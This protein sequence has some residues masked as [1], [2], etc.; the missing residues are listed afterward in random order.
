MDGH[1][2][3]PIDGCIPM[4]R[5]SGVSERAVRGIVNRYSSSTATPSV[6]TF[7]W[8]FASLSSEE[9]DGAQGVWHTSHHPSSGLEISGSARLFLT[10]SSNFDI[11][12]KSGW[13][14]VQVIGQIC[15]GGFYSYRDGLVSL[16]GL[17]QEVF[18]TQPTRLF[19]H[20]LYIRGSLIERWIFDRSGMYCCET[21]NT[22]DELPRLFSLVLEY[23]LLPHDDLGESDIVKNDD[24]GRFI[25]IADIATS[26]VGQL[27]L[28][29]KPIA[30]A[31]EAFGEGTTCYRAKKLESDRWNFVVKFKWRLAT[32]RPEEELLKLANEK[33]VWGIVSLDYHKDMSRTEKLR[34]WALTENSRL[35]ELILRRAFLIIS[36]KPARLLKIAFSPALLLPPLAGLFGHSERCLNCFKFFAMLLRPTGHSSRMPKFFTRTCLRR[37]SSS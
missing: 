25:D 7:L 31:K 12:A 5:E 26:A 30:L 20:G 28:E 29:D 19:L 6:K 35:N 1:I 16:Y 34:Q 18:V 32:D 14:D 15:G 22:Q 27:Y 21:I 10:H 33:N 36:R 8:W 9:L 23:R 17:A 11:T 4:G 3:G 2:H 13:P 24:T 37:I